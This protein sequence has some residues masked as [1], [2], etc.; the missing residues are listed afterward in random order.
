MRI[1]IRLPFHDGMDRDVTAYVPPE[2][3]GD[4]RFVFC[5]DGQ[6]VPLFAEHLRQE[7]VGARVGLIGIHS[8]RTLRGR[9]YVH[10]RDNS[11]FVRHER[12]FVNIVRDWVQ[13]Q[14]KIGLNAHNT[15]CFGYSCGGALAISMGVRHPDKFGSVIALSVAGRP[16]RVDQPPPDRLDLTKSQFYLA[17][18]ESEPGG[19]KRYMKRIA[20][21]LRNNGGRSRY[22]LSPGGHEL[23]VWQHELIRGIR[24]FADRES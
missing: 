12:F 8:H 3:L 14:F 13:Q 20:S 6:S 16:V 7:V 18:G 9:E 19:M 2:P 24:W 1:C 23:A 11:P 5:A 22:R 15:T 21:W 10:G 17:A 4:V